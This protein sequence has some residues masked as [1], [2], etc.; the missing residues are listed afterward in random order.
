MT[1]SVVRLAST[2]VVCL[3]L[4]MRVGS[5]QGVLE[6]QG[7]VTDDTGAPVPGAVVTARD[8]QQRARSVTSGADGAS[9]I[10]R[11]GP[12]RLHGVC[13]HPGFFG[14]RARGQPA[15]RRGSG[16]IYRCTWLPNS[17]SRSSGR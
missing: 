4:T 13:C 3:L 17:V 7:T 15:S 16:W 1:E 11:P 5:A 6:L 8:S 14:S 12:R 2:L 10:P 9:A